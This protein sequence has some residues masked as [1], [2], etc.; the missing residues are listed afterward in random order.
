MSE[1]TDRLR[2]RYTEKAYERGH[3]V[4]EMLLEAAD[5]IDTLERPPRG[6]P[7]CTSAIIRAIGQPHGEALMRKIHAD[8]ARIAELENENAELTDQCVSVHEE[9]EQMRL[10]LEQVQGENERLHQILTRL[11]SDDAVS[12]AIEHILEALDPGVRATYDGFMA[13]LTP[14]ARQSMLKQVDGY[15][16][17]GPRR[18]T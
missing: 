1:L 18:G 12:S 3:L 7:N 8:E 15:Y 5:R 11:T 9:H 6:F 10:Q 13:S 4:G 2:G 16:T 14:S 17:R